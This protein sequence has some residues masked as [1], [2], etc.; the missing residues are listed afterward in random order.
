M[1]LRSSVRIQSWL[2]CYRSRC[3]TVFTAYRVS[4][5]ETSG[6]TGRN[7]HIHRQSWRG[8]ANKSQAEKINN[9][10]QQDLDAEGVSKEEKGPGMDQL[11]HVS[12]E[13]AAMGEIIGGG[14]PDLEQG[15]PVSEVSGKALSSC[16]KP[17]PLIRAGL[18]GR[19]WRQRPRGQP[20]GRDEEQ[21]D[22]QS[23]DDLGR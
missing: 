8:Y 18:A 13:A 14:Q 17:C 6:T 20:P 23:L 9:D 19:R 16:S 4:G 3:Q 1:S 22:A 5:Q 7:F 12:E 21:E 11:P 2:L 15:T 10:A